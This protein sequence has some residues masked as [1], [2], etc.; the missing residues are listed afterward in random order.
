MIDY[1]TEENNL[2]GRVK[3]LE[4]ENKRLKERLKNYCDNCAHLAAWNR[5]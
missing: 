3:W 5:R 4:D 1:T 2:K